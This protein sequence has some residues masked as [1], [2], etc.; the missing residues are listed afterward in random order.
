MSER[1]LSAEEEA[2]TASSL[3]RLTHWYSGLAFIWVTV[4][5]LSS[6]VWLETHA[7]L[8]LTLLYLSTLGFTVLSRGSLRF[9]LASSW[10]MLWSDLAFLMYQI[11][12]AKINFDKSNH[13]FAYAFP[14]SVLFFFAL[15]KI[16]LDCLILSRQHTM[17]NVPLEHRLHFPARILPELSAELKR[18][19][20]IS[21]LYSVFL[22]ADLVLSRV[23]LELGLPRLVADLTLALQVLMPTVLSN[24]VFKVSR[25]VRISLVLFLIVVSLD[26][27][28]FWWML[29]EIDD[30]FSAQAILRM[31]FCWLRI[32]VLGVLAL[33][34][35]RLRKPLVL[36]LKSKPHFR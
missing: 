34:L 8:V 18:F 19:I 1:Y 4:C 7:Q 13:N 29:S 36:T 5:S 3:I 31:I 15:A 17:L 16:V 32:C 6:L 24:L 27:F 21:V 20:S 28:R 9:Y 22:S 12:A 35:W 10:F 2:G 23:L 14:A 26:V 11:F 30:P 33:I 25:T